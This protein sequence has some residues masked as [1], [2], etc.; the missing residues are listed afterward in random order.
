ML[1]LAQEVRATLR[2]PRLQCDPKMQPRGMLVAEL[3]SPEENRDG[4]RRRP[5]DWAQHEPE[6]LGEEDG[7]ELR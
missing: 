4:G 5:A 3:K 1:L 7:Y 6:G 2:G